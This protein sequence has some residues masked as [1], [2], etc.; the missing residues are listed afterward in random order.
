MPKI[1]DVHV[2]F[3]QGFG[4][5]GQNTDQTPQQ[6]V[7]H[8]AMRLRE[9]GVAKACL[10]SGRR[11][12]MNMGVSHEDA[13]KCMEPHKDLFIPV[14]VVDPGYHSPDRIH[15]LHDMGYRGL[16]IIGTEKDYDA[17]EYMPVYAMAEKMGMPLLFHTGV[18]GGG[19]DYAKTHPRRDP[20]AADQYRQMVDRLANPPGPNDP[21]RGFGGR[22]NVSAMRMR[23]FHL[24]T[25][26]SNFPALKII[27]AHMGGTGNYDEAAS[28]ARWRHFVFFDMSGGET[29]ERHAMERGLIGR[30]IGVEK[31]VW[32]SDCGADEIL[33]HVRRFE[34]MFSL[35]NLT[36]DQQDRLWW[37]NSAEIYGL[38]PVA[39]APP[40]NSRPATTATSGALR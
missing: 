29:I 15:E 3:P 8:L 1:F 5:R 20:V 10:L 23:P 28:V 19:L 37:H 24:D 25:I 14:A 4:P 17:D 12:Q 21:Q 31:L 33:T 6:R 16:K 40:Q 13:L 30:E 26:G 27:G 36:Q 22:R 2:H 39:L 38:E 32:G 7:D 11:A 9:A 34:V 18:I 35:M